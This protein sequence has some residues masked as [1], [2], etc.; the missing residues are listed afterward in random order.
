MKA[1]LI[2]ALIFGTVFG[3][4]FGVA[5]FWPGAIIGLVVSLSLQRSSKKAQ[6]SQLQS[7]TSPPPLPEFSPVPPARLAANTKRTQRR[8]SL[9]WHPAG[10]PMTVA[11]IQISSGMLYTV[12][13]SLPYPGE[14]SAINTALAV[15]SVP[16]APWNEMGYYPNY[17]TLS[18]RQ[19][20]TY[21]DWLGT[22]RKY[23]V[24]RR[25]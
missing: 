25:R 21:L 2:L 11:G 19:R 13:G 20:R 15:D 16:E 3:S 24:K 5:G 12:D 17:E 10:E 4:L 23:K 8:P 6:P 7:S 22:D 9:V 1:A 14:P 18:D